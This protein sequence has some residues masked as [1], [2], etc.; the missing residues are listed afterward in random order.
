MISRSIMFFLFVIFVTSGC[1]ATY[2]KNDSSTAVLLTLNDV[3][4]DKKTGTITRYIPRYRNIIIPESFN[5]IPVTAI[6]DSAFFQKALNISV[7]ISFGT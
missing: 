5:G 6:G 2:T 3:S 7:I 4:F 1:A